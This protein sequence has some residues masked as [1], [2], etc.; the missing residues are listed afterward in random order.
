MLLP[1]FVPSLV[2][3]LTKLGFGDIIAVVAMHHMIL[4]PTEITNL[5]F[6]MLNCAQCN[7]V[8]IIIRLQ[9]F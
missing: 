8:E 3:V 7:P 9:K 4:F 2:V 5:F 6:K 1:L